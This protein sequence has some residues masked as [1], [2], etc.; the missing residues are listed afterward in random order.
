MYVKDWMTPD[1]MTVEAK[2]SLMHARVLM[3]R[4]SIRHLPVLSGDR[5]VGLL[6]DRDLRDYTP[7]H[8][9]SLDV[10]EMHYLIAKLTVDDAMTP[11]PVTIAADAPIAEAGDLMLKK[12]IGSLPVVLD[13]KVVGIL[14]ETDLIRALVAT[15]V[16]RQPSAAR[17]PRAENLKTAADLEC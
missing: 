14:T 10:F 17:T 13:G 2:D 12:K 6:S 9:T 7:S 3:K 4:H 15:E 5:I 11:R 1:P 8:C 16:T